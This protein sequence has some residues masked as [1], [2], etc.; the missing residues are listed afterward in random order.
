MDHTKLP[1]FWWVLGVN[2]PTLLRDCSRA[3]SL[4]SNSQKQRSKFFQKKQLLPAAATS[5]G[6]FSVKEEETCV[7]S[8]PSPCHYTPGGGED[9]VPGPWCIFQSET[10]AETVHSSPSQVSLHFAYFVPI[11]IQSDFSGGTWKQPRH[12]TPGSGLA[13]DPGSLPQTFKLPELVWSWKGGEPGASHFLVR[14]LG[15]FISIWVLGFCTWKW[16]KENYLPEEVGTVHSCLS[17][18]FTSKPSSAS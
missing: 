9:Q 18:L 6:R 5:W 11:L 4:M 10:C 2:T 12:K 7:G 16:K 8:S 1:V 13:P 14:P 3:L 17:L 15:K